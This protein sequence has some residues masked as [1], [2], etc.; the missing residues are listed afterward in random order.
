MREERLVLRERD[1]R[2]GQRRTA[3]T[4]RAVDHLTQL[5]QVHWIDYNTI[6]LPPTFPSR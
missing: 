1:K 6:R 2:G 5:S 4:A 3:I